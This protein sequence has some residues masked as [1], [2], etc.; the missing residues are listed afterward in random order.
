M[1]HDITTSQE[2][3]LIRVPRA[4]VRIGGFTLCLP[5]LILVHLLWLAAGQDRF[6]M[7]MMFH[8]LCLWT[9]GMRVTWQGEV[10]KVMPDDPP[11][12]IVSNHISY[13]DIAAFGARIRGVFV[14]KSEAASWPLIGQLAKIQNTIFIRRTG[15]GIPIARAEIAEVFAKNIPVI[16]Y[17]EGTSWDGA[18]VLP[19]K[20]SLLSVAE[21]EHA[22]QEPQPDTNVTQSAQAL[23]IIP[24]AITVDAINGIGFDDPKDAMQDGYKVGDPRR[25]IYAWPRYDDTSM[26]AHLW[27][28]MQQKQID[29]TVTVAEPVSYDPSDPQNDRKKVAQQVHEIVRRKV[30]DL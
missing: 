20:S 12:M 13:A 28:L 2:S 15:R 6:T 10:P 14:A 18:E 8:R 26:A 22:S 16:I 5:L 19:F 30:L 21:T 9:F 7:P 29:I 17:L 24:L 27:R 3:P 25:L 4:L 23:R 1:T 11:T